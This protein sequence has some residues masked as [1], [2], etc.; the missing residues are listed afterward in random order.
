M[1][2]EEE[3]VIQALSS[4]VLQKVVTMV[5]GQDFEDE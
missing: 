3:E 1:G 4:Q 5:E 2:T